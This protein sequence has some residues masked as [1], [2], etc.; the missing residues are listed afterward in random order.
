MKKVAVIYGGNSCEH[1]VSCM[2]AESILN[3]IDRKKFEVFEIFVDK[4]GLFNRSSLKDV[5]VVFLAFHGENYEDGSFQ[6]YLESV[7]LKY[8]GSGVEASRINMDKVLQKSYFA[9]AGLKVARHLSV[10][11]EDDI[12]LIDADIHRCFG[13]PVIVKP[14]NGGSSIG[15]SKANDLKELKHSINLAS[16]VSHNIIIE[17]K[18]LISREI[19]VAVLGNKKLTISAPGEVLGSGNIYSYEAKYQGGFKTIDVAQGISDRMSRKI[20]S[21]ARKSYMITGCMGYA[22][23]DFFIDINGELII[24]EINTLPGFTKISMFP[25]LMAASGINYKK[26]ITKIILLALNR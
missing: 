2:T 1:E 11:A 8:T 13:Y 10:L 3:H 23:I 25:K 6:K 19:E 7:G 20:R 18:I 4:Q 12:Y 14:V 26:L 16:K 21:W 5:D 15:I 17:E 22:R 9:R 24:N